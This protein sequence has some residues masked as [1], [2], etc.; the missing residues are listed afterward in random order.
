MGVQRRSLPEI[1]YK[2]IIPWLRLE[3]SSGQSWAAL[4]SCL[5]SPHKSLLRRAAAENRVLHG[6]A[7]LVDLPESLAFNY[8]E[9]FS[10]KSAQ[11]EVWGILRLPLI[12]L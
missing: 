10:F 11:K 12:C 4:L 3:I 5:R 7:V 2:K 1:R 8:K 6:D 9:V